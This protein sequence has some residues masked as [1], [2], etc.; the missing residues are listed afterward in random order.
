VKTDTRRWARS[1][2]DLHAYFLTLA[3]ALR[4]DRWEVALE[5]GEPEAPDGSAFTADADIVV[6]D[7]H[8]FATIRYAEHLLDP[9]K[10]GMTP[11]YVRRTLVHEALHLFQRDTRVMV[12]EDLSRWLGV[13][14]DEVF[15]RSYNRA[16]ERGIEAMAQA[17]APLLPLP[18]WA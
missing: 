7:H 6:N 18:P 16:S 3:A 14:A 1:K 5:D 9:T 15:W 12:R 11:D 10:P 17:I 4:L 13:T 2:D 8:D